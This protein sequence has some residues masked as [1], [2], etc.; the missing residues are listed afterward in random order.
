MNQAATKNTDP[1]TLRFQETLATIEAT[2]DSILTPQAPNKPEVLWNAMR[3]GV[4]NGGKR[5]RPILVLETCKAFG[6]SPH[7]ALPAACALELMHCYSLIHDDLPCMD[8]D[9]FRR[10]KPTVHKA[11][12]EDIAV[13]AGDA[14]NAMAFG[15][16]AQLQ[17]GVSPETQVQLVAL[18]SY[19]ASTGG[20]VSGQVDDIQFANTLPTAEILHRIH[21]GK[22]GALFTFATQAGAMLAN[23]SQ[24][25]VN[26]MKTFGEQLGLAFQIADDLLDIESS[27]EALGKSIGKDEAQ[28]KITFPA[29]YGIE[30][31]KEILTLTL[32]KAHAV[33]QDLPLDGEPDTLKFIVDFV[34]RRTH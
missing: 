29:V 24:Y 8:N 32:E 17:S 2:L 13:L 26:L 31:S 15:V 10:G 5:I 12:S 34:G 27:T 20:V 21:H 4:L 25:D 3:H 23:A 33:L 19:V 14:L 11:F 1:Y 18:F 28:G 16:M 9:D 6:G 30:K 22:T 7:T